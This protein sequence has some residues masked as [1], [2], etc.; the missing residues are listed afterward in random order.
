MKNLILA[1][2]MAPS[3]LIPAAFASG[4]TEVT[5]QFHQSI[6]VGPVF[7]PAGSYT[8]RSID[9]ASDTPLLAFI[10]GHGD[11]FAI[12]VMRASETHVADKTTFTLK[13]GNPEEDF[14][15]VHLTAIQIAGKDYTYEIFTARAN[16]EPSAH[17]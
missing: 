2:A 8:I 17:K 15:R 4:Q 12:P 3:T 6:G 14:G 1:L 13:P 7:L 5:V 9:S 10:S 11:T 16:R